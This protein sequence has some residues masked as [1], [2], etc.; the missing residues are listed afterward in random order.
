MSLI[1]IFA[2]AGRVKIMVA[3]LCL[4]SVGT[5]LYSLEY[6]TNRL[7][8]R[9]AYSVGMR[10]AE[11]IETNLD[12][13]DSIFE[14]KAEQSNA[15]EVLHQLSFVGR[16]YRYEFSDPNGKVV[17]DTS[18]HSDLRPQNPYLHADKEH[19]FSAK[20]RQN[21]D[22]RDHGGVVGVLASVDRHSGHAVTL[23]TGNGI[24][25]P[26]FYSQ[27]I[28]PISK[29]GKKLGTLKLYIDQTETQTLLHN[30]MLVVFIVLSCMSFLIFALPAFFYLQSK[31]KEKNSQRE[32]NRQQI[33]FESALSVM[34]QGFC[35]FDG[36]DNVIIS[37][38]R[39]A[40][41]YGLSPEHTGPGKN[42]K[43]IVKSRIENGCYTGNNPEEFLAT[44]G[45]LKSNR[46]GVPRTYQLNDG[47]YVE[48]CDQLVVDGVWFTTH[49]DVTERMQGELKVQRQNAQFDTALSNISQ[50]LCMFD[51][52]KNL[53]VS[54]DR[55]ATLFGL[56]PDMIRTKNT[57][58][59]QHRC[60]C[61]IVF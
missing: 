56:S 37:N 40:T 24:D 57:D 47:R 27:V 12:N 16:I 13:L 23:E 14:G 34:H 49:E 3:M 2:Q 55:Y 42:L 51:G 31:T 41:I 59:K 19:G 54:N 58:D 17:F 60:D 28:H 33:R 39:Y 53:I 44:I 61:K 26:K 50:G 5:A 1:S 25:Q 48:I 45:K 43:D 9:D 21:G 10:W 29:G 52:N 8:E 22:G 20:G 35:M 7:L 11:D 32:L 18:S 36:D 30:S 6:L 15:F 46:T 38:D 4:I